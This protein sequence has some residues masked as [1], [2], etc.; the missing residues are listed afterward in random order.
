VT[1]PY[2]TDVSALVA[3]FTTTGA[4]VKVGGTTQTRSVTANDFIGP[5]TYTV[6][7]ADASFQDY[8]VTVTKALK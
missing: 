6:T 2:G 1:V 4:S 5:V 8:T 3:T 7:A